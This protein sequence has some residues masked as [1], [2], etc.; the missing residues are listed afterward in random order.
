MEKTKSYKQFDGYTNY[1]LH[2]SNVTGGKMNFAAYLPPQAKEKKVPV[3]YWLSGLTCTEENFITKAYAQLFARKFGIAVVAPDTSPRGAGV[4]GEDES[5][6]L[7]TGAGFYVDAT[8]APWA[9]NYKMYSY[10]TQELRLL[11]EKELPVD[12]KRSGIF[13]HSMGGHGALVL[14]LRNP[15]LYRS[16]SAFAP[17]CAPVKAPWGMK[18]FN[19]YLGEDKTKWAQYDASELVKTASAKTPILIDQ[20]LDDEFLKDQLMTEEFEKSC[21]A[22]GYPATIRRRE[23]YDHSYFFISTFIEEHFAFHAEVLGAGKSG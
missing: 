16:I 19:A 11:V 17:I 8:K 12:G 21:K 5:Y 13:G 9:K 15:E 2:A 6:D 22:A 20:G 4:P 7:G 14:G 23:G 10:I 1:Y 3:L 18:A